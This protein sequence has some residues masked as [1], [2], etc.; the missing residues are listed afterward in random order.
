MYGLCKVH[1]EQVVGFPPFRQVFVILQT[2]ENNFAI[3]KN[4]LTK[5]EYTGKELY[6]FVEDICEQDPTL[7]MGG[8]HIDSHFTNIFLD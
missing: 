7:A 3:F 5:N 1:K 8:L 6:Q 2:P 4:S